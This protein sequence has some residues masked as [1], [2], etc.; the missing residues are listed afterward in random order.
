MH[1][2]DRGQMGEALT[3]VGVRAG[4]IIF[5]HANVGYFGYPKEGREPETVCE[6]IHGAFFDV[7]G[8]DGTLVMPGF[9]YSACKGEP[10]DPA[11]TPGVGGLLADWFMARP[12]AVRSHDPIFSVIAEG[13]RAK[14]MTDDAPAACFGKGS[15]WE[16][17]VAAGGKVV[18]LNL[19]VGYNAL[20]HHVE[21][22][23]NASWRMEKPFAGTVVSDGAEHPVTARYFCQR[24]DAPYAD[25]DRFAAMA[26]AAGLVRKARV[27][28]GQI[29]AIEADECVRFFLESHARDE[30]FLKNDD[31]RAEGC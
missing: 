13:A 25:Y 1:H 14:D 20:L 26:E 17:L 10:F 27:G 4:D 7:L 16:R 28:R 30:N 15:F 31:C 29:A 19:N 24:P 21:W 22:L 9:S 2:Y 23:A 5:S 12:T 8:P 3:A 18:N 11:S 6:T